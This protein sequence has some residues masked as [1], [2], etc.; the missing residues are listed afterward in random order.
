MVST[1]KLYMN[2]Q[3]MKVYMLNVYIIHVDYDDIMSSHHLR[4]N[5][6]YNFI[7][8]TNGILVVY[9]D[10]NLCLVTNYSHKLRL[11]F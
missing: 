5:V 6:A 11:F 2:G 7:Y 10:C 9:V 3:W 8:A 4:L 1:C